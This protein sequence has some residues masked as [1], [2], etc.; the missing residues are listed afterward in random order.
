MRRQKTSRILTAFRAFMSSWHESAT[1]RVTAESK[2]ISLSF[3]FVLRGCCFFCLPVELILVC[4]LRGL[5]AVC[6]MNLFPTRVLSSSAKKLLSQAE[7]RGALSLLNSRGAAGNAGERKLFVAR[8]LGL[9]AGSYALS[10]VPVSLRHVFF[11][12]AVKMG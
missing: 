10:L 1:I 9:I 8:N 6:Q 12:V 11:T 5:R 7:E 4:S 2:Q 3:F